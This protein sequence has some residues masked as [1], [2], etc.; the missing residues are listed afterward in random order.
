MRLLIKPKSMEL[1]E[2]HKDATV[3]DINP[4][5][6]PFERLMQRGTVEAG[7]VLIP[8]TVFFLMALQLLL[9]G[10]W[11]SIERARLHDLVIESSI[12]SSLS[13]GPDYLAEGPDHLAGGPDQ[14]FS[15]SSN[16]QSRFALEQF[17]RGSFKESTSLSIKDKTTPFGI[18]RTFE[19]TTK[20]PI[21][22]NLFQFI[23][24]GLFQVKNYAVTMIS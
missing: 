8:T 2:S 22:G 7:L 21:L 11:Q 16:H 14:V 24:G 5:I 1:P 15:G 19:M 18:I 20:L 12:K 13:A 10:S 4:R 6:D 3:G 17:E 23:D 9:A